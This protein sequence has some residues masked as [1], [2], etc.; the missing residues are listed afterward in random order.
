MSELFDKLNL[1]DQRHI[2]VLDAPPSFERE[3]RELKGVRV[4][5]E[6]RALPGISFAIAFVTRRR[7][8]EQLARQLAARMQGDGVL[9]FAYPKASSQALSCDFNRDSGWE[10][11]RAAGFDSVRQVAIDA[12]WSGLRFRRIEFINRRAAAKSGRAAR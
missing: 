3:L 7:R 5:R 2:L 10:A 12:D 11:L 1:K 9:W 6:L 4:T 8:L